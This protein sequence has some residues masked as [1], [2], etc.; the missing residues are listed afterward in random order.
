MSPGYL[1]G[2]KDSSISLSELNDSS[3]EDLLPIKNIAMSIIQ[4][5]SED[6]LKQPVQ[7]WMG[8]CHK[9]GVM[10]LPLYQNTNSKNELAAKLVKAWPAILLKIIKIVLEEKANGPK[11]RGLVFI[12]LGKKAR[13]LEQMVRVIPIFMTTFLI[14][15]AF[16]SDCTLLQGH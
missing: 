3:D 9:Q 6:Q 2:P 12:L 10:W 5:A 7:E 15:Y 11:K 4:N 13:S 16:T 1:F 8:Y 14:T